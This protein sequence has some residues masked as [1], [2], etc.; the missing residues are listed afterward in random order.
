MELR[1]A[2]H[3]VL[4]SLFVAA[5]LAAPSFVWASSGFPCYDVDGNGRCESGVDVDIS[6]DLVSG[7][8]SVTGDIV[9]PSD[10]KPINLKTDLFIV[11]TGNLTVNGKL[12]AAS[13]T[14][15]ADE[16]LTIGDR[17]QLQS[18]YDMDLSAGGNMSIGLNTLLRSDQGTIYV[19]CWDGWFAA[20]EGAKFEAKT[21]LDINVLL[22]GVTVDDK[23]KLQAPKG[24]LRLYAGGDIVVTGSTLRA[25][26]TMVRTESH[27]I[28]LQKS[29]VGLTEK[30]GWVYLSAAG[31]TVNLTGTKFQNVGQSLYIDAEQ[32]IK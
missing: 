3:V 12:R 28:D 6:Q 20:A 1:S 10:A 16:N 11:A 22:N 15:S 2:V 13:L 17:A 23:S 27:L 14:L 7:N 9:I 26:T 29:T 32:V 25:Q 24:S 5:M 30:D 31:S 21:G 19:L 8:V 4:S 18:K